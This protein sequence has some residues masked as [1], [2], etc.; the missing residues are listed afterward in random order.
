MLFCLCF[1]HFVA[2]KR[3]ESLERSV[4]VVVAVLVIVQTQQL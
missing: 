2:R 3:E 4:V 1:V